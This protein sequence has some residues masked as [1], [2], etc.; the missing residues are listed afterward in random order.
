[1][2]QRAWGAALCAVLC[3]GSMSARADRGACVLDPAGGRVCTPG[4]ASCSTRATCITGPGTE[5]QT[6]QDVVSNGTASREC[7]EDCTTLFACTSAGDCPRVNDIAPTCSPVAPPTGAPSICTWSV[8]TGTTTPLAAQVTYCTAPGNHIS[9]SQIAACHRRADDRTAFTSDYFRGDCDGD[10]CPN[11]H[12]TNPCVAASAGSGCVPTTE[13]FDSPFCAPPPALACTH[14]AA[15]GLV[16]GDARP[17]DPDTASSFPCRGLGQCEDGWSDVP[18]CRPPCSTLFLCTPGSTPGGAPLPEQCPDLDGTPGACVTLPS[19]VPSVD[20]RTGLCVYGT[21]FDASCAGMGPTDACF[22][23][24]SGAITSN[25][26]AGD[27]DGD[28]APN[29]C[30]TLRCAAGGGTSTCAPAV[31]DGCTPTYPPPVDAGPDAGSDAG[32]PAD[33]GN[34]QTD[35][36]LGSDAGGAGTDSGASTPDAGGSGSDASSGIDA[37]VQAGFS[38]GGGCR[39]AAAGAGTAPAGVAGLALLALGLVLG[40]RA[41]RW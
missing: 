2:V 20:G 13:P 32:A 19:G 34:A 39:C 18:R 1:M 26:F 30:D 11:G 21:F 5:D 29:A 38:G 14:D 9:S 41:R 28:G 36:A 40:R 33:A 3:A 7:V 6:C 15:A 8:G 10:G 23:D 17:C 22:M 16:C 31:G 37:G 4:T 25:Y 24:P 12:D 27:C 35:A